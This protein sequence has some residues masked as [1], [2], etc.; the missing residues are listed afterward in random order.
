MRPIYPLA[1]ALLLAGATTTPAQLL[2]WKFNEGSG[3][4]ASS[5]GSGGDALLRVTAGDGA[6][7][8]QAFSSDAE[9]V[10]GK[11]GDY[12][13]DMG[14]ATGM[15]ATDPASTGPG[16]KVNSADPGLLSLSGLKSFTVTGWLKPAGTLTAAARIIVSNLISVQAG[17]A[18]QLQLA[19]NGFSGE[20]NH[21]N[22]EAAYEEVGSWMFFAITYDGTKAEENV[23]FY[24]GGPSAGSGLAPAGSGSIPAGP[25]GDQSGPITI[26]NNAPGGPRPFQGQ[27]DNLAIYGSTTDASGVLTAAQLEEVHQ[28][29]LKQN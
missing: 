6:E 9:G 15:G 16:G 5:D 22:S 12:A 24:V 3:T 25:L 28:A 7:I 11:Q 20:G 18:G 23:A 13:L 2:S 1:L 4:E 27:I 26:G 8:T 19:L 21:L 14:S 29:A 10:S 17:S